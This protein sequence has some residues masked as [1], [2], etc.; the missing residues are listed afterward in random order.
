MIENLMDLVEEYN[1]DGVNVDFE[2]MNESDKMYIQD[3]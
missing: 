2:N 3:S 1:L